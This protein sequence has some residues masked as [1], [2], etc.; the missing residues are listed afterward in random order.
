M[1]STLEL[2]R[3]IHNL[4]YYIF[5]KYQITLTILIEKLIRE[6]INYWGVFVL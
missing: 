6:S 1:S 5:G 3:T 2:R 4:L